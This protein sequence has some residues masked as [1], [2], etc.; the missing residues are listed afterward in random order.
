MRPGVF[1]TESV[2]PAPIPSFSPSQ[3]AGAMVAPLPSGPQNVTLV[4]SWYQFS[5]IF[6]PLN[7]DF[8]ATFAASIF[9]RTGGRE[10][11]VARATRASALTA[12]AGVAAT[13]GLVWG[14]FSAVSPGAYGNNLQIKIEKNSANLYNIFVLQ[15]S[16]GETDFDEEYVV[17]SFPNLDL[18]TFGSQEVV[19]AI[20]VR[21]RFIRFAWG[22]NLNEEEEVVV[23]S[24]LP[25]SIDL[26]PLV[27]GTD[28]SPSDPFDYAAALNRLRELDRT[29]LLFSP[30]LTDE[31]IIGAMVSFAEETRSFVVI[32]TP[33]DSTAS[34]ATQFAETVALGAGPSSY[35]AVY[36]P[37]LWVADGT[38]RSRSAVRKV[39]PSAAVAGMILG[40]DAAQGVFK[41][42]AGVAAQLPGVVALER[43][44]TPAQLDALNNDSAPVNA[45]RN[46]PGLGA[47]VMGARTLNMASATKFINIRRSMIFLNREMKELLMFALFRNSG[48]ELWSEMQTVIEAYLD[49]FWAA[50]GLRGISREQAFYV[51]I[52][53]ENNSLDDIMS[54]VVNVEIGVALQYPAEFIKIQLTQTTAA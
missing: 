24:G 19:D 20:N 4:T 40:T 44:L 25:S 1:V 46:M 12:S 14:T 35:A 31:T 37:H 45:I 5:R 52:D 17:E 49:S 47:V 28:G 38:S 13:G 16:S 11:Y 53:E 32:D 33:A 42:P 10:L 23:P 9:F 2:L 30:G 34:E 15:E 48:P 22:V 7:R 54:G 43:N 29:L 21:S 18:G 36:Y 39:A 8:E 27:G 50:G 26:L 41:A 3:A 51:K 6:G